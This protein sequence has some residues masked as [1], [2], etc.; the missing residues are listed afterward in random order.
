MP[1]SD[2]VSGITGTWAFEVQEMDG[3]SQAF[4]GV[5]IPARTES[6]R[7]SFT[8]GEPNAGAGDWSAAGVQ[9]VLAPSDTEATALVEV[10]TTGEGWRTQS[11]A[12][13]DSRVRP[14][15]GDGFTGERAIATSGRLLVD[16]VFIG[17]ADVS[18]N[19]ETQRLL[20]L[21]LER[22]DGPLG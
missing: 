12:A 8:S 16:V 20:E 9:L 1:S 22:A 14:M 17:S 7:Y 21:V 15:A 10:L 5:E 19:E 18:R 3:L 13:W 11:A 4:E 6:L 2:D